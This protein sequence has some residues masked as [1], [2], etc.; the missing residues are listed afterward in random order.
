MH[1]WKSSVLRGWSLSRILAILLN[2]LWKNEYVSF[3]LS[4]SLSVSAKLTFIFRLPPQTSIFAAVICYMFS[5]F[6]WFSF[7]NPIGVFPLPFSSPTE[8]SNLC[9]LFFFFSFAYY[10]F[11]AFHGAVLNYCIY[12]HE[13][14]K[15]YCCSDMPHIQCEIGRGLRCSKSL[16]NRDQQQKLIITIQL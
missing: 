5:S 15:K 16:S 3:L 12:H 8:R 9:A 2:L 6:C 1:L 13:Q 10:I 7:K 4:Q 11:P 14:E